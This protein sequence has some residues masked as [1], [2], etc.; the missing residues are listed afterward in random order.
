MSQDGLIRSTGRYTSKMGCRMDFTSF[1]FDEQTCEFD[2]YLSE[3][4]HV[5]LNY[6][7]F[8]LLLLH[9]WRLRKFIYFLPLIS[10]LPIFA[11]NCCVAAGDFA[12]VVVSSGRFAANLPLPQTSQGLEQVGLAVFRHVLLLRRRPSPPRVER[13]LQGRG[14]LQHHQQVHGGGQQA[15]SQKGNF[16]HFSPPKKW[17]KCVK[18]VKVACLLC[19]QCLKNQKNLTARAFL[20]STNELFLLPRAFVSHEKKIIVPY[21]F[22]HN[23]LIIFPETPPAASRCSSASAASSPST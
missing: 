1:P 8:A 17:K 2:L 20:G 4:N 13:R 22:P 19:S 5:L 21:T 12:S 23:F 14:R 9:C 18:K 15:R 3:K 11:E 10:A 6:Y 16:A 7:I